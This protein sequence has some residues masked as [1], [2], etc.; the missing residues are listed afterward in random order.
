[1]NK[2]STGLKKHLPL[3]LPFTLLLILLQPAALHP[4]YHYADSLRQVMRAA[5]NDMEGYN[6]TALL[7]QELMPQQMDS[8]RILLERAHP[9]EN[10]PDLYHRAQYHNVWGLYYWFKQD[11]QA[12]IRHF[13]KTLVLPG[14][15]D[16]L[17]LQAAAANNIGSHFFRLGEPDSSRIYLLKALDIDTERGNLAGAAK[18]YYDL[19][20]LHRSMDQFE[21]ALRY[22]H[23][24][25][26]ILENN[27]NKVLLKHSYNVLGNIHYSLNEPEKAVDAYE[28]YLAMARDMNTPEEVLR[29]YNNLSA[30]WCSRPDGLEQ[31]I[32]Y[33]ES[34]IDE[35]RALGQPDLIAALLTNMGS[36]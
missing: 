21:L 8:A 6:A 7:A 4:Q 24:A 19:S 9:L 11:R 26:S 17:P 10:S 2:T 23:Q 5:P 14:E 32:H 30:L 34:G 25:I 27:G 36:A 28:R 20:R 31:T 16:I 1:M 18:N 22:I 12:S 15:P 13:K 3:Y 29:A 33:F 35:A